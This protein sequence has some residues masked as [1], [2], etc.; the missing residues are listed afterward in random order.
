[1][2]TEP[3]RQW[4]N[5]R[6]K[7]EDILIIGLCSVICQGEDYED[8]E[9]FRNERKEWFKTFLELP[10]ILYLCKWHKRP[11]YNKVF[12]SPLSGGL[13]PPNPLRFTRWEISGI[14]EKRCFSLNTYA[15]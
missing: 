8:M 14:R 13:C 12:P 10:K 11:I 15:Y 5:V 3:R 7:L 4:G 2:I 6:H 9:L 1:M